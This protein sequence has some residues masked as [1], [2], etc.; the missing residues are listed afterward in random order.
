MCRLFVMWKPNTGDENIQE[1][2]WRLL[3]ELKENG[4]ACSLIKNGEPLTRENYIRR[5]FWGEQTDDL[6]AEYESELPEVFWKGFP[7]DELKIITEMFK[8]II[9]KSDDKTNIN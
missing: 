6:G 3:K 5:A 4:D 8:E 7:E 2:R 1:M 9:K